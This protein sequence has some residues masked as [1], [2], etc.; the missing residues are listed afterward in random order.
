VAVVG[1]VV[2]GQPDD[3]LDVIDRV[4]LGQGNTT[5][6]PRCSSEPKI[7]PEKTFGENG[8]E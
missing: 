6:S 7:R 5:T 3:A 8:S 4:I 1:H 2:A